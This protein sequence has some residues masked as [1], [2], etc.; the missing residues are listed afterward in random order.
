M[1]NVIGSLILLVLVIAP[2]GAFVYSIVRE[3]QLPRRVLRPSLCQRCKHG[4]TDSMLASWRCPECGTP[5]IFGGIDSPR[6]R[7]DKHV[8]SNNVMLWLVVLGAGI[9][10]LAGLAMNVVVFSNENFF[11]QIFVGFCT[12][13]LTSGTGCAFVKLRRRDL[14]RKIAA[15][16]SEWLPPGGR[17]STLDDSGQAPSA[18]A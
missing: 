10:A 1:L 4:L 18:S 14:V 8:S 9:G 5:Y 7:Y 13:T 15:L 6:V 2:I 11:P 16:E 12:W 3:V 17:V